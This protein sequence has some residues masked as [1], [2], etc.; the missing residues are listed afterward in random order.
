VILQVNVVTVPTVTGPEEVVHAFAFAVPLIAQPKVPLGGSAPTGEVIVT[1]KFA[2]P[3]SVP[4]PTPV[5]ESTG[6][7]WETRFE[8]GSVLARAK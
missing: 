5:S 7:T 8:I 6:V 1:V 3:N 2:V 4:S